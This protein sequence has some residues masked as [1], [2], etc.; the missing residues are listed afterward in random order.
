MASWPCS[1]IKLS[2]KMSSDVPNLPSHH[3]DDKTDGRCFGPTWSN[4]GSGLQKWHLDQHNSTNISEALRCMHCSML[5]EEAVYR[6]N[7]TLQSTC[8]GCFEIAG[9]E[10]QLKH[11]LPWV[12]ATVIT[13]F[14]SSGLTGKPS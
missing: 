8:C 12:H 1:G 3:E 13:P 5:L 7:G 14:R 4:F 6:G 10:M 2:Q 9:R 11:T